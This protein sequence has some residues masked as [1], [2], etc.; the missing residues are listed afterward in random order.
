MRLDLVIECCWSPDRIDGRSL[1]DILRHQMRP[2]Q[3]DGH[4][5][6]VMAAVKFNIDVVSFGVAQPLTEMWSAAEPCRANKLCKHLNNSAAVNI[7]SFC[8][9]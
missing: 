7:S 5:A 8:N 1:G 6:F 3:W 4:L 9:K 2:G